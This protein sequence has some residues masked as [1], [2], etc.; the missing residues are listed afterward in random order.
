MSA[1][2]GSL[3]RDV[4]ETAVRHAYGRLLAWLAWQWR[5]IAAAEDALSDALVAALQSWP[6]AGIPDSPEGWL[7][8]AAKRNLMKVDRRRGLAEDPALTILHVGH[9]TEAPDPDELPDARLRLLFACAHPSI[10]PAI[11]PALMMQTV[12]GLGTDRIARGFLVPTETMSKRLVRAK[13]KIR[14]AGIRYEEAEL[15]ELPERVGA[16][17]TA[18]HGAYTLDWDTDP[19]AADGDLAAEARFLTELV[20]ALLPDDA[21]A[22]GLL[23]LVE[24]CEARKPALYDDSGGFVPLDEQD[25]SRWDADLID[26]A[27][28]RLTRAS[29]LG[30]PGPF[31]L[32]AAIQMAHCSRLFS[33][34]TPWSDIR[35][36][37]ERLLAMHSTVGATLG[38][39]M[40]CAYASGRPEDGLQVLDQVDAPALAGYQPWWAT[41]AHLLNR[42]GNRTA[43]FDAYERAIALTRSRA[44]TTWLAQRQRRLSGSAH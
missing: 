6:T 18:I 20:C 35:S 42:C 7:M 25:P 4:A 5:D 8:A 28:R 12:L 36:L 11:Q 10:D 22:L 23:A 26:R 24:L 3:A 2:H 32:Q 29:S 21:E 40:A 41:R 16:V 44:L 13:A 27:A 37:Y 31:Q 19:V 39:A 9:D 1:T 38:Y 43:A 33:G 15:R 17:L 30:R 14:D 34:V